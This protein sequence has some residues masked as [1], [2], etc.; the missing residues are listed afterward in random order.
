[1]WD[2]AGSGHVDAQET[3][4]QALVRDGHE[5]LGIHIKP[6]GVRFAHLTDT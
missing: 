3:A 2:I 5:E 1:M 6:A 4:I